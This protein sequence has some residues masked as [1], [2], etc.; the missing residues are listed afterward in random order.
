MDRDSRDCTSSQRGARH[1]FRPGLPARSPFTDLLMSSGRLLAV[2]SMSV[3]CPRCGSELEL[4]AKTLTVDSGECPSCHRTLTLWE[5]APPIG[6]GS[7]VASEGAEGAAPDDESDAER[8]ASSIACGEC[9]EPAAA[10]SLEDGTIEA[11]C[12]DCGHRAIY[13]LVEPGRPTRERRSYNARPA[14]GRPASRPCRECGGPLRFTTGEDGMITGECDS[15]GNRFT[16][17]PRREGRDFDRRGRFPPGGGRFRGRGA[18]AGFGRG[19]PRSGGDRRYRGS[20]KGGERRYRP[21]DEDDDRRRRRR[22]RES[23]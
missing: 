13:S 6:A 8:P 11:S 5:G 14:E 3:A 23:S 15:C 4:A 2:S 10:R 16:L 17:P 7:I 22:P 19:P 20:D 12:S 21:R 9:G 18:G 1:P